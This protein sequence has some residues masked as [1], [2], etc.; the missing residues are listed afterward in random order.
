MGGPSVVNTIKGGSSVPLKFNLYE[1]RGGVELTS[2]T[3]IAGFQ[4][5]AMSCSTATFEDPVEVTTTGGTTLRYDAIARQ[6]IQNWQTPKGAGNCYKV[7]MTARDGTSI[8][9]F[10]KTK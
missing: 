5:Y 7:A 10:F 3:D 2:T 9:A 8:V 4:V 1:S 6:F